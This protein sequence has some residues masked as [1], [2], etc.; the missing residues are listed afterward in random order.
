MADSSGRVRVVETGFRLQLIKV[1]D[2]AD[3]LQAP[4]LEQRYAGRVVASLLEPLEAVK[5]ELLRRPRAH[6]S[7][8]PAHVS[9]SFD[10]NRVAKTPNPG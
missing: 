6:V 7:D 5:E 1:A 8:D 10:W 4:V 9:S 3:V 2:R